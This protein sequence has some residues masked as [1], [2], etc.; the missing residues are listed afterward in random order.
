MI[1][2]LG[3]PARAFFHLGGLPSFHNF[4]KED[5]GPPPTP[6]KR[7]SIRQSAV[8]ARHADVAITRTRCPAPPPP[9]GRVRA[10]RKTSSAIRDQEAAVP[11]P[12]LASTTPMPRRPCCRRLR[13]PGAVPYR[14]RLL[15]HV[16]PSMT[17]GFSLL[18][19]HAK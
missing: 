15:P 19:E 13:T 14:L 1:G 18:H 17:S 5:D 2:V 12:L 11:L 8:R 6:R 9:R 10:T 4:K 3:K 7:S 16:R